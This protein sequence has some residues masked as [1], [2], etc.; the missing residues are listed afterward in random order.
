VI[1]LHPKPCVGM[2]RRLREDMNLRLSALRFRLRD[3]MVNRK[4]HTVGTTPLVQG[5]GELAR[6]ARVDAALVRGGQALALCEA[7]YHALREAP[8]GQSK[9]QVSRCLEGEALVGNL[10]D[11]ADRF[12]AREHLLAAITQRPFHVGVTRSLF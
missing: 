9:D 7:T 3:A 12:V 5:Q 4:S 1:G 10:A 11:L 2:R 6:M 8:P